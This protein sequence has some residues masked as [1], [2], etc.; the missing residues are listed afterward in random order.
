MTEMYGKRSEKEAWPKKRLRD[1]GRIYAGGTPEREDPTCWGGD[2]PWL[3]P[4]DISQGEYPVTFDTPELITTAGLNRSAAVLLP[5]GALLVTSRATLGARTIAG[6]SMTTN[7]GFKNVVFDANVADVHFYYHL[8]A[9]LK[10]ELERR[11]SGTTFLEISA[12]D[13]GN[14]PVPVPP[15]REQRRIAEILDALDADIVTLGANIAKKERVERGLVADVLKIPRRSRKF[16]R[17]DELADVSSGVT[18]GS[19]PSGASSVELPYLR[20]A[21]VQDGFIDTEDMKTVH[22]LKSEVERLRLDSGDVLLTEGG[23][24]DKLGRG[25]VWDGRIDPCVYQNHV[26]RVRCDVDRLIPEYFALYVGSTPGRAYFMS[27]AKQTTNL[28]TINSR[29][30][31]EMPIPVPPVEDQRKIALFVGEYRQGIALDRAQ[32]RDMKRLRQGLMEDLLTGQVQ[33]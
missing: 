20:V 17:L 6:G 2:I 28:A 23:D 22:V 1:I 8:F 3:T 33:V 27:I 15:L 11:A 10:G 4:G 5:P 16:S 29:Q 13:F 12:K 19:E 26:F 32:L 9:L 7:Q 14:I 30:L 21:N 24:W 18:L 25:A 31:K